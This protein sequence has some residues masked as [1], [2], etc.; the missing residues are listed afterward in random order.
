MFNV[1]SPPHLFFLQGQF[2]P[3]TNLVF[4]L[5]LIVANEN[6][7]CMF[8]RNVLP[9]ACTSIKSVKYE[10]GYFADILSDKHHTSNNPKLKPL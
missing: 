8:P 10:A 5:I 7:F 9:N 4:H 6:A 3:L 2:K 1:T